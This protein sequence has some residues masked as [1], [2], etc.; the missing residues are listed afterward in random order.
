MKYRSSRRRALTDFSLLTEVPRDTVPPSG[1]STRMGDFGPESSGFGPTKQEYAFSR[2]WRAFLGARLFAASA[3][4]ALQVFLFF[5]QTNPGNSL[6]ILPLAAAHVVGA[7]FVFRYGRSFRRW[8]SPVLRW[9]VTIAIDIAVIAIIQNFQQGSHNLTPL[10]A[11]P[12]LLAAIVGPLNLGLAS[13]AT[14]TLILL[15]SAILGP[16]QA[17]EQTPKLLEAAMAGT[18]FF[19]VA[20]LANQLARRLAKEEALALS[21]QASAKAQAQVNELIIEGLSEGVV[22]TDTHGVVRSANP[23]A[24]RMLMGDHPYPIGARLLLSG[25]EGW[26]GIEHLVNETFNMGQPLEA[27]IQVDVDDLTTHKLFARTRLTTGISQSKSGRGIRC[28]LFLEDLREVEARVRTEKLA[29][30]GRMSAAVAH[31]IRNPLSAITQANA[32]LEEEVAD[33]GQKRLTSMI[34]QNAQRLARIV[35]DILNLARA[36]PLEPADASMTLPLDHTVRQIT[37]EWVRQS[38]ARGI[39]GVHIHAPGAFVPFD[40]EHLRRLL[41]NLL[42]NALRHASR[43]PNSIRVITQPSGNDRIRLSV[44]SDGPP[45]EPS[46]LNHLFEPFFSSESRSSGLGLYICR[47]LC[48]RYGAQIS[49]QRS[50]LDNHDGNEFFVIIPSATES[51]PVPIQQSLNYPPGDSQPALTRPTAT[52]PGEL[53][54]SQP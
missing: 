24:Q 33:P 34:D 1:F 41:I 39:L 11:L 4:L 49:Y 53:G 7:G 13:A 8:K 2:I 17:S 18:G 20:F 27:E 6:W 15:I 22:I 54:S 38:K 35:D 52:S 32:L 3:L 10:Y 16:A 19:L 21:S 23:A 45:L 42:D 47:E 30:M 40:A 29:S 36:Q 31:E 50:A 5:T 44:W 37:H 26:E 46:V 14:V 9:L 12:V 25:R 48:E 28:V 43:Q 51:R